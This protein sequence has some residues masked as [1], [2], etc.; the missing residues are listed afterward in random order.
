MKAQDGAEVMQEQQFHKNMDLTLKVS[1]DE[2]CI[3]LL[4]VLLTESLQK[5]TLVASFLVDG[6][7]MIESARIV[8]EAGRKEHPFPCDVQIHHPV[9]CQTSGSEMSGEAYTFTVLFYQAGAVCSKLEKKAFF[10]AEKISSLSAGETVPPV[11][12]S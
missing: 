4:P 9:L 12:L 5:K 2:H 3:R 11:F 10:S 1:G 7:E 6:I 8:L